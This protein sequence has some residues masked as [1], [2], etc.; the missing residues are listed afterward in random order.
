MSERGAPG[1]DPQA[2]AGAPACRP[3]FVV[4]T[5][6][7]ASGKTTVAGVIGRHLG[8]PVIDK[9]VVLE[10]LF[11]SLGAGDAPHRATLSRAADTVMQRLARDTGGAVLASWWRHPL[12][13]EDSGTPMDWLARLPGRLVELHCRCAPATAWARFSTRRRHA[14]HL[15]RRRSADVELARFQA[16]AARGPAGI[17]ELVDWDAERPLDPRTLLESIAA[18]LARADARPPGADEYR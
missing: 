3:P 11:D 5:G 7:P 9:D 18:A 10:A 14:G 12:S 8:L 16:A 15:D 2:R 1:P 17:G 13:D 6:L 4:V